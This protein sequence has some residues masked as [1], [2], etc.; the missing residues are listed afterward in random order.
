MSATQ[1]TE[2]TPATPGTLP[3]E[4]RV[5]GGGRGVS[6]GIRMSL[7]ARV[8]VLLVALF[9]EKSALNLLVDFRLADAAHGLAMV[10]RLTQHFGLRFA[11]SFALALGFFVYVRPDTALYQINSDARTAPVRPGLLAL[12]L[13]LLIPVAASLYN[14]YGNHG[15]RLPFAL[16][17][18]TAVSLMLVA[19][20]ALLAALAPWHIW[21]GAAAAVGMR[22]AYAALAAAIGT[23]AI[24]W[25]Q[26]LW[27][28]TAQLTFGLVRDVLLPILPTLT[29][30]AATRVLRTPNFAVEVSRI[31]S[32]LEGVGL[33]LA[34]C[35]AWLLYFRAEYR[36]PR[37]LLIIPA[38]VLL[39]F[40][41]NVVRI[42]AL[43]LIGNAGHPAIA[44][45]GFHS[46]AGWIFFNCAACAVAFASRRIGWLTRASVHETTREAANP[47]AAYL[48]PFLAI[49]AAG[50]I[51]RAAS[52]GFE[53]WY[54]LRLVAAAA[55][56][57]YCWRTLAK[58]DWRFGWPGIAVGVGIF[59]I[60]LAATRLLLTPR[61]MPAVLAAMPSGAK[62]LWIGSR[63][64]SAIVIV[65]IAEELAY[66][67]Y[68]LRRLLSEDF[69]AV[70]FGA[71]GWVPWVVAAIAFGVVHG[72][73]W[74][75]GTIAGLAY[76]ALPIRTGRLGEAVAA[77]ATTNL[78][79]VVWVLGFGQWQLW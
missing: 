12:H 51:S 69:E 10:L 54:A 30:D 11:V 64:F 66:R 70:P 17:T 63:A 57:P 25:S 73:L 6:T 72:A 50:M 42:A 7:V 3:S 75:P 46:Q 62:A 13:A 4:V 49:L 32:G 61:G 19:V 37:A 77:H 44:I 15:V 23:G 5:H 24:L 60:W 28:P 8:G 58:L 47:T 22:W 53:T 67:G 29:S 36:F 9:A 59:A 20:V 26:D 14:L 78:L 18:G 40:A 56:F 55:V 1:T 33:M 48:L 41:L 27:A 34:F 68:L 2:P 65:P 35:S 31:C 71:V 43:V 39:V 74:L 16:L 38:G 79:I 52:S 21:R 45:Y 76:G